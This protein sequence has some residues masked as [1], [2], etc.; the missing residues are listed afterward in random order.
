MRGESKVRLVQPKMEAA[1]KTAVEETSWE[2]VDRGL[3]EHLRT[4]RRE[5]AQERSV[6]AF[7]IFGD[8]TLREMARR[9][10]G[11]RD[12]LRRV[13]G[14]GDR[15]LADFGER[16]TTEITGYCREHGLDVEPGGQ[17]VRSDDTAYSS[18]K[19]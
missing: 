17:D 3:F 10:P 15:K 9:R 2:G 14:V 19:T 5:L 7:V 13:R 6:P 18:R 11:S 4:V 8:A 16:F 1:G 12:A